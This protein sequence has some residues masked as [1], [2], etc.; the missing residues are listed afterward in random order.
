MKSKSRNWKDAQLLERG[1]SV[2]MVDRRPPS[3]REWERGP[4][5]LVDAMK[6]SDPLV[7]KIAE[8]KILA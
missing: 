4:T 2:E 3:Y 8:E 1:T 7:K 6:C 5:L